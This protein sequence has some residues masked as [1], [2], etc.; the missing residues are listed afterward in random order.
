[1]SKVDRYV[2]KELNSIIKD[3]RESRAYDLGVATGYF[4]L[5]SYIKEQNNKDY[6]VKT[7]GNV[8]KSSNRIDVYLRKLIEL[9]EEED[10]F[11]DK[12]LDF[13]EKITSENNK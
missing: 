8:F 7:F 3:S 4:K 5:Y 1:M 9:N 10:S 12:Y 2:S 6:A 11:V 13:Q